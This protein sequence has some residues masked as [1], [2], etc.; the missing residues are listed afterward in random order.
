VIKTLIIFILLALLVAVAYFT[1]PSE[2][3][4]RAL[5][6]DQA[7][8]KSDTPL[9][10]ILRGVEADVFLSDTTFHDHYLWTSV[11]KAGKTIYLGAVAH[12]FD[13]GAVKEAS[14]ESA[15]VKVKLPA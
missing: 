13:V 9:G 6:R 5:V 14:P 1:R 4:F 8:A 7:Q 3:S 15:T 11:D 2:G 12:W 10:G